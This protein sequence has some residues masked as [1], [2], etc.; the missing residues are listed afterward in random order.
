MSEAIKIWRD[1]F[2]L[3][4]KVGF[5][6]DI[7]VTVLNLDL[8]KSLLTEWKEKKWNPLNVKG[9]ISEYERRESKSKRTNVTPKRESQSEAVRNANSTGV[10]KRR[11]WNLPGVQQ[12]T[13][14]H[15]GGGSET[16][17]EIVTR[18]LRA[19]D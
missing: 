14:V 16:L 18:A 4:L 6:H 11:H 10:P 5:K 9:M 1:T 8:W 12:A 13:G 7:E 19:K 2:K 15:G 3:N 17:E